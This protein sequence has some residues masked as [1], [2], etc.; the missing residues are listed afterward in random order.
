MWSKLQPRVSDERIQTLLGRADQRRHG[1]TTGSNAKGAMRWAKDFFSGENTDD[2]NLDILREIHL[3]I[4]PEISA[5]AGFS[6]AIVDHASL[7]FKDPGGVATGLHQDSA[8]W[9]GREASPSIF[10][11]WIALEDMSKARGALMLC[12]PNEVRSSELSSFNTGTTLD[13][14]MISDESDSGG[15]PLLINGALASQLKEFME[16]ID[17]KKGESVAFDSFEPHMS[18]PNMTNTPR[19]AMKIAYADFRQRTDN[20]PY[21]IRTDVLERDH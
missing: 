18:A 7:L 21:L 12:T 9:T 6:E 10:S 17:L 11:V 3:D 4:W 15:F 8:Y 13:H 2:N 19:R 20:S 1:A 16:V 14:E 5:S